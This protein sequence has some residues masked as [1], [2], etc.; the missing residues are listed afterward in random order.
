VNVLRWLV[1]VALVACENPSRLDDYDPSRVPISDVQAWLTIRDR[2]PLDAVDQHLVA[3][4][5]FAKDLPHRIAELEAWAE[6]DGRLVR[7]PMDPD[8]LELGIVGTGRKIAELHADDD[9]ALEAAL[10]LAQRLRRDHSSLGD[11]M[12]AAGITREA[13]KHRLHAPAFAA[14]YAPSDEEAIRAFDGE[15]MWAMRQTPSCSPDRPQLSSW[16]WL[17]DAPR[18]RAGFTAALQRELR[19]S[20]L[21]EYSQ[22]AATKLFAAVD[23]YQLWL[24][25]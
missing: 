4:G 9:R 12:I 6:A 7:D 13:A 23:D 3:A 10:H 5:D 18:D 24:A 8:D 20:P 1:L 22:L 16:T 15:A 11:A 17:A 19:G 21:I 25:R 14:R 2:T